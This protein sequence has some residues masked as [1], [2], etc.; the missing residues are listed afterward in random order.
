MNPLPES[1]TVASLRESYRRNEISPVQVAQQ[2]L[3]RI[4]ADCPTEVFITLVDAER[5]LARARQLAEQLQCDPA[6]LDRQALFGIPYAIK[7]NIDVAG[8]PTTCA[9]PAFAYT[10]EHSAE[11]VERIEAAGGL[12]VGKTN[13]DQFA[14][15]LVGTRS[16]YGE[17]KNPFNPDYVSGGSSSGSAAAV[18]L[19][20]AAFALGTDTAGS[21]RVPAGFCNLVGIKPTPGLVSSRGVFPACKSLDCVSILA[22]TVA[23]G[24]DVLTVLAG[25]DA[26]DPYSRPVT[27]LAPVTRK[28][29]IGIPTP[30]DFRGDALAAGA[31][32][33]AVETLQADSDF[34]FHEV[35]FAPFARIAAL[36]YDGPWVAERRLAIADFYQRHA[37]DMNPTVRAVIGKAEGKTAVD[38]FAAAYAL[39]AGKRMAEGVFQDID[40][41]LVPTAPTHYTRAEIA[42]DPVAKNSHFG[43]YTNFVNLLG[44]SALALPGPF[45]SDGLPAGITLIAA[46]GGDHR[47]AEFARRIEARLHR[48][49]GRG[50]SEPPRAAGALPPLPTAE[51]MVTVAV[52]GAHLSGMPLNWQL[53]E[54]GAR[55][56]RAARTAPRYRLFALPGTVPPKPGLIQVDRDGASIEIE[57]WQMPARHYGGFVA[58]I[59][60]PLGIG[61]LT[62]DDGGVVQGF[63]CE[64]LAT[65][66]AEDIT[67]FGGW[68]AYRQH[69]SA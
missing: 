17:V 33:A 64:A 10:P 62:L 52:V 6:V 16:P 23:D 21:G 7:D 42:A 1:L 34:V 60:A 29:R 9:C 57:V 14:T 41:M 51:P 61:T 27:A 20:F 3:D 46:G 5:L 25:P 28:L 45:R 48:R 22:H 40:L 36:L 43:T 47:L 65:S 53:A 66:G 38:A 13:L 56:L 26:G 32:H 58:D 63:L 49:L 44:M 19:G 4:K 68:R 50:E 67:R 12:L 55:L 39:E 35:P 31:F 54:R 69:A 37:D 59:P 11:V 30:L 8:M 18:A 15:G 2:L 24:W